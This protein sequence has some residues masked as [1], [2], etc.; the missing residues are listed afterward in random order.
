M[1][2]SIKCS[3]FAVDKDEVDKEIRKILKEYEISHLDAIKFL[4]LSNTFLMFQIQN[5]DVENLFM[6]ELNK[7]D[8]YM[9]HKTAF[10]FMLSTEINEFACK[11]GE[12]VD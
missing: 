3:K 11:N 8:E 1:D 5:L 10:A 9:Q 2:K 7:L 12:K 4:C 6:E